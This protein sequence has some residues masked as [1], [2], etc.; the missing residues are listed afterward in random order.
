MDEMIKSL[1]VRGAQIRAD[2]IKREIAALLAAF[3]DLDQH[4][5]VAEDVA[6]SDAAP[7]HWTQTP[8]G[9]AKQSARMKKAWKKRRAAAAAARVEQ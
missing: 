7:Y 3:P 9:R 1:A 6:P 2:A 8:A 5:A 4:T